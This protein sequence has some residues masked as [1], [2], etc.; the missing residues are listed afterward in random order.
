MSLIDENV[1][2]RAARSNKHNDEAH[3]ITFFHTLKS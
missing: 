2:F 1:I 3:F